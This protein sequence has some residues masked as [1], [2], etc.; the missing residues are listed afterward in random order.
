MQKMSVE[1]LQR[2]LKSEKSVTGLLIGLG[3][4]LIGFTVY[5][6]T[7]GKTEGSW[8]SNLVIALCTFATAP[9]TYKNVRMIQRELEQRTK[10]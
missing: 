8:W 2:R 9:Y 1:Q 6:S 3:T 5:L 10:R 7:S 4:V